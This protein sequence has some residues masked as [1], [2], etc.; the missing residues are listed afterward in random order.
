[1]TQDVLVFV[2]DCYLNFLKLEDSYD[3]TNLIVEK[4]E[5]IADKKVVYLGVQE[6]INNKNQYWMIFHCGG[7][8]HVHLR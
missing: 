1:M 4:K 5:F 3:D 8:I 7:K 6:N 2:D